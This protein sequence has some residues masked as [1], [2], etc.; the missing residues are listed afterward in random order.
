MAG[1]GLIC[2]AFYVGRKLTSHSGGI[3]CDKYIK[4]CLNPAMGACL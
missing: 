3:W 1:I 4:G 2:G